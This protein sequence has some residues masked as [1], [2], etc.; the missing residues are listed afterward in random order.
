MRTN[1][2]TWLWCMWRVQRI[3]RKRDLMFSRRIKFLKE[4]RPFANLSEQARIDYPD[5]FLW[6]TPEDVKRAALSAT[7]CESE[8]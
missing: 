4:L 6:V 5:A 7:E 8:P 3:Y 1:V 2:V